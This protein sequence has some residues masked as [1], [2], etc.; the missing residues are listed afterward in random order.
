[1]RADRRDVGHFP[2]ARLVAVCAARKRPNGTNVDA[3]AAFFAVQMILAVRNDHRLRA[4]S[5]HA[6]RLDV[7]ALV[8]YA[9]AAETQ[10]APGR[11]V[12][13]RFRPLLLWLM[14]LFFVE[15][16]LVRAISKNHI[17]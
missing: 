9:H 12:I 5:A 6:E 16:A 10:N 8:A 14:A 13:D 7:H 15:A 3:H 4:A 1:M 11:V 2:R 17:L